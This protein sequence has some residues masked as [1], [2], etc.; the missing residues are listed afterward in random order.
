MFMTVAGIPAGYGYFGI[1]S[2][3]NENIMPAIK[4]SLINSDKNNMNAPISIGS[5]SIQVDT[6]C[7]VSINERAPVLIQV[8]TGLS[9]DIRGI[10]S[11]AFTTSG[12]HY[13]ICMS[14]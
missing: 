10:Y 4:Q 11:L 3:E 1:P 13:N 14:Y 6:E 12:I 7:F 5:M 8:E 9:F 2:V